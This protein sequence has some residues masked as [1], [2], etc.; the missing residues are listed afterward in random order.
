MPRMEI[1][2]GAVFKRKTTRALHS[3]GNRLKALDAIL[4]GNKA[5]ASEWPAA[6]LE[7]LANALAVY[8]KAKKWKGAG[9]KIGDRDYDNGIT[10][11]LTQ[12]DDNTRNLRL[13]SIAERVVG[14]PPV[15]DDEAVAITKSTDPWVYAYRFKI[16]LEKMMKWACL[17][18]AAYPGE[19]YSN[20]APPPS[21][22]EAEIVARARAHRGSAF[23]TGAAAVA[24]NYSWSRIASTARGVI[25]SKGAVC[26]TFAQVS[27]YILGGSSD[28][29]VSSPR[30]EIVSQKNHVFVLLG[31]TGGFAAPAARVAGRLVD[32]QARLPPASEWSDSVVV[33]DTWLGSLGYPQVIFKWDR[34]QFQG[35]RSAREG[36]NSN[37]DSHA[38]PART[39]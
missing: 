20:A 12:I 9:N 37:F 32:T 16:E 22:T 31:R 33:V 18:V 17:D 15:D 34:F 5:A 38:A 35:T 23:S 11:L 4:D 24:Q 13:R 2:T 10:D 30:I 1:M 27:A 19:I 39:A 25:A 7:T 3:R 36:L 29:C 28:T 6:Q 26:T 8:A 21:S 14:M